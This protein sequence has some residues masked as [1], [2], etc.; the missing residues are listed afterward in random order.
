MIQQKKNQDINPFQPGASFHIENSHLIC[1]ANQATGFYK[2]ELGT[3]LTILTGK[4]S[5][6]LNSL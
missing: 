2:N 3:K 6:L 5:V 4:N 1:A